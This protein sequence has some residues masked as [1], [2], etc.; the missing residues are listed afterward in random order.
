VLVGV[1]QYTE[2]NHLKYCVADAR[3]LR[4]QLVAAGFPKDNVFL[5]ADGPPQ[6]VSQPV[7]GNRDA[8]KSP[9]LGQVPW[10]AG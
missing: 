4:D 5:L 2:L 1:N 8:G 7:F 3:T 6:Q 10:P 9:G